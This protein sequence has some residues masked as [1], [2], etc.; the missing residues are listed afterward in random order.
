MQIEGTLVC[1]KYSTSG[2]I[3][4]KDCKKRS[5]IVTSKLKDEFETYSR[6]NA[7]VEGSNPAFL[8][9]SIDHPCK[10]R[11]ASV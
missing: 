11:A 2:G 10:H 4:K 3:K 6:S 5:F 8:H 9:D 1:K 7:D